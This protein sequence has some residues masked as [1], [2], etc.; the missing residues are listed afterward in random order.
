VS[1]LYELRILCGSG[2]GDDQ[3]SRATAGGQ[4]E[5][6]QGKNCSIRVGNVSIHMTKQKKYISDVIFAGSKIC[7]RENLSVRTGVSYSLTCLKG[8]SYEIDFKN[9]E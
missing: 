7:Q 4:K 6:S 5:T 9:V 2:P 1:I 3:H 8:L